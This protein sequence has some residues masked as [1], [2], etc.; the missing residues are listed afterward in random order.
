[1]QYL[2]RAMHEGYQET[3]ISK[4]QRLSCADTSSSYDLGCDDSS[5]HHRAVV[6]RHDDSAS[7]HNS[8]VGPFRQDDSIGRSQRAKGF[9]SQGNHAQYIRTNNQNTDHN[10]STREK[11]PKADMKAAKSSSICTS[12]LNSTS[13][14]H[15]G[16]NFNSLLRSATH[17]LLKNSNGKCLQLLRAPSTLRSKTPN[18]YQSKALRKTSSAPPILLQTAT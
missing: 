11:Y 8:D 16:R 5:D 18:W 7:H 15:A 14:D 3:S 10:N 13:T 6:F 1:M 9:S 2:K 17:E 4:A 12:N